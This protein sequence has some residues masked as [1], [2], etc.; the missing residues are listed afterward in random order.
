MDESYQF[1][2]PRLR[3]SGEK[4]SGAVRF[5]PLLEDI[6]TYGA[7]DMMTKVVS[8]LTLPVFTRFLTPEDY[9]I[10]TFVVTAVG[11]LGAF[12]A[13]GGDSAFSLFFFESKDESERQLV[14]STWFGFLAAWSVTVVVLCIPLTRYFSTWS[15]GTKQY[16]LII[17]FSLAAAPLTLLNT[18]CGQALRN[19]F[20]A[21]LFTVLNAAAIVLNVGLS[22]LGLVVF[23]LGLLGVIGGGLVAALLILPLR[24]WT[25]RD[26]IRPVFST[27]LLK[28]ILSFG[29]PLVP[30]SLAY[31][32]FAVSDRMVLGKLSTL[33][34]VGFYAIANQIV[35]LLGFVHG[36][37]GQAWS[38]HATRIYFEERDQAPFLFGQVLTYILLGFGFLCVGL[39]TFAREVLAIFATPAFSP[40]ALAIG[41]L[42]LGFVAY[43]ST[44]VTALGISFQKKTYYFAFCSWAAALFNLGFNILLI[45]RWGMMAAC[46]TTF[47]AYL[48]LTI[49]YLMISQRLWPIVYEKRRNLLLF[50]LT[51][52]FTVVA[53]LI[54]EIPLIFSILIKSLYVFLFL[55]ALV[56]S[57]VLNKREWSIFSRWMR[58]AILREVPVS[59]RK[60]S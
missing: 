5:R 40:A 11:L 45:P 60:G 39:T 6:L 19:R 23:R 56:V 4:G 47:A 26:L 33:D 38:P 46:W 13:L 21:R 9:G 12:L 1:H 31:W 36:A 29:V 25:I 50:S 17:A 59:Q 24:L 2:A 43:A 49:A 15:F 34:Q 48:F 8:L 44:N 16:T 10:W 51:F 3:T 58:E 28:K 41:P 42:A 54:P 53:P 14:T 32:V 57:G 7:G 55:G 22:L 52:V 37:M 27:K 35:S 20:R 18:M 30:S